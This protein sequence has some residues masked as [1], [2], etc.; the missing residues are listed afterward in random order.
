MKETQLSDP[1]NIRL[2][3]GILRIIDDKVL[4]GIF[5]N[6]SEMV[7]YLIAKSLNI[8]LKEADG[9]GK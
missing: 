7:R 4:L 5:A 8:K 3:R 6:R 9:D 2:P 1:I